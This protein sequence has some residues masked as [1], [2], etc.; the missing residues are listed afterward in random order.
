M[1]EQLIT[2]G[3]RLTKK[4]W[5]FLKKVAREEKERSNMEIKASHVVRSII[6]N[7]IK[8]SNK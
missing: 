7:L 5:V 4:Q 6:D 8:K 2:R 1:K 3:I